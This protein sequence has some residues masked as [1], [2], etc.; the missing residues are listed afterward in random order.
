M[1]PDQAYSCHMIQAELKYCVDSGRTFEVCFVY[2]G[3]FLMGFFLFVS[4]IFLYIMH[5]V[6]LKKTVAAVVCMFL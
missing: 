5:S 4:L 6:L 3:M 1:T 2:Q